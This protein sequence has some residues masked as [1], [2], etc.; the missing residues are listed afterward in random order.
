MDEVLPKS[1]LGENFQAQLNC[2]FALK[3]FFKGVKTKSW[4]LMRF[5]KGQINLCHP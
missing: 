1:R 4:G 5:F 2:F 3:K